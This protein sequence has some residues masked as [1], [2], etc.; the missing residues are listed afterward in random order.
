MAR[1]NADEAQG[2]YRTKRVILEIYDAMAEAI[3]VGK[4]YETRLDPPPADP[5][6]AH[7]SQRKAVAVDPLFPSTQRHKLL[8]GALLDL[9][10]ADPGLRASAYLEALVL[11]TNTGLCAKLL[12]PN[13]QKTLKALVRN[14]PDD[15]VRSQDKSLHWYN[16][17]AVLAANGAIEVSGSGN[18]EVFKPGPRRLDLR[19]TYPTISA[20]LIA[21]V[22]KATKS[23]RE[24]QEVGAAQTQETKQIQDELATLVGT[25]LAA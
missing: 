19:L 5:R 7:P 21:H 17:R 23:L 20:D 18:S 2:E 1:R 22:V 3:R 12:H 25:E 6:V 15:L 11:V 8:C 24:L 9:I 4:P 10:A 14:A 16:V 13:E